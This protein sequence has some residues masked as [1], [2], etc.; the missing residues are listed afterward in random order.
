M[1]TTIG[2]VQQFANFKQVATTIWLKFVL[3]G[4]SVQS[5]EFHFLGPGMQ[6]IPARQSKKP[7]NNHFVDGNVGL[8]CSMISFIQFDSTGAS[9]S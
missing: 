6:Q 1:T 2:N 4:L 8:S 3:D 9:T 7:F 5:I